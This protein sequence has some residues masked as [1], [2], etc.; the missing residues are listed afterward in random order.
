VHY[1]DYD[2]IKD[3]FE[4]EKRRMQCPENDGLDQNFNRALYAF[5]Y[6]MLPIRTEILDLIAAFARQARERGVDVIWPISPIDYDLVEHIDPAVARAIKAHVL[7]L[8][9]AFA[10]RDVRVLDLTELLDNRHFADRWCAC[11]HL[12][13]SGRQRVADAWA[14]ALRADPPHL[15]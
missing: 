14:S 2:H 8:K 10:S 6:S 9:A 12:Q 13:L 5:Q 3:R 4:A 11:G 1:P 15:N 7:Q